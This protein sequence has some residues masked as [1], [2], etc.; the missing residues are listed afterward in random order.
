MRT[1][2]TLSFQDI[3]S[4]SI[5]GKVTLEQVSFLLIVHTQDFSSANSQSAKYVREVEKFSCDRVILPLI[6]KGLMMNVNRDGEYWPEFF[7]LTDA[8]EALIHR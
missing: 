4:I 3:L 8:G 2:T 7:V 1:E 5:K 6:D